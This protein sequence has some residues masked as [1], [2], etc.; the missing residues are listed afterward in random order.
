MQPL[1]HSRRP[2]P[3]EHACERRGSSC[4]E[5]EVSDRDERGAQDADAC[6]SWRRVVWS[7]RR[8]S[9]PER[10]RGAPD[11][12]EQVT[13]KGAGALGRGHGARRRSREQSC[14]PDSRRRPETGHGSGLALALSLDEMSLPTQEGKS[15]AG[16][17]A[18]EKSVVT[19]VGRG[20]T[21]VHRSFRPGGV[22]NFLTTTLSELVRVHAALQLYDLSC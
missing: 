6:A 14:R 15:G 19:S 16:G 17:S 11:T 5:D 7:K 10:R 22:R 21:W 12:G 20:V 18:T 1:A 13:C 2:S 3:R 8:E 9:G 4:R